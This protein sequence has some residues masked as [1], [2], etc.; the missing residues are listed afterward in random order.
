[1]YRTFVTAAC[2]TILAALA[3]AAP[4][5]AVEDHPGYFPLE[6]L[7]VIDPSAI[8]A[9]VDLSGAMLGLVSAATE[10]DDQGL[11][12]VTAGLE[13]V[14]VL[15]GKPISTDLE[16]V[17]FEIERAADQLV[18]EGWK[19]VVKVRDDEEAVRLLV[20]ESGSTIEGMTVLV[21]D[22]DDEVV[23]VNIVGRIDPAMLGNLGAL[24]SLHELQGLGIHVSD[25][26]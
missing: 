26:D 12:D 11:S 16:S 10:S 22:G 4:P 18:A 23:L 25:E 13:R 14:R 24:G 20:R 5:D 2:L 3:V 8:E 1:M 17:I 6:Q 9:D 7:Q 21:A 15:V 19:Q